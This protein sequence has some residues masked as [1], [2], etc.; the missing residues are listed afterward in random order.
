MPLEGRVS[1]NPNAYDDIAQEL[2]AGEYEEIILSTLPAHLSH[3]LHID[4]PSR[5]AEL[6][7]PLT[8]VTP[9]PAPLGP[10]H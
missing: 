7:Y 4:L 5:V 6:G 9:E 2:A 10:S 1:A 8:T 3:W